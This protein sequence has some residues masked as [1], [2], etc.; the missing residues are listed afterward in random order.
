[1]KDNGH[2]TFFLDG[3]YRQVKQISGAHNKA[4]RITPS[5]TKKRRPS[6]RG[7]A[8]TVVSLLHT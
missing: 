1:M 2:H 8:P 4:E 6:T 7:M 3:F 5:K